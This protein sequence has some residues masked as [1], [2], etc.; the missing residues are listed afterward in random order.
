MVEMH[1]N[2]FACNPMFLTGGALHPVLIRLFLSLK[3]K[4]QPE[5][6]SHG[7]GVQKYPIAKQQ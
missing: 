6:Q 7:R 3:L 5:E 1:H 4:V 2:F